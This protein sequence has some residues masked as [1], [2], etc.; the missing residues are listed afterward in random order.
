M[1]NLSNRI[2]LHVVI[3]LAFLA[4]PILM[5]PPGSRN[6][7]ET[8][9]DGHAWQDMSGYALTLIFFYLN[10]YYFIPGYYSRRRY[11][12]FFT[13]ILISFI[14]VSFLPNLLP[15][16]HSFPDMRRPPEGMN[17]P[18]RPQEM[19]PYGL[20]M[21]ELTMHLTHSLLRFL[22]VFF[23]SLMLKTQQQ[24]KEVKREKLDAELSYLKAQINPHF[25]FN[26]LNTIYSLSVEK[27]DNTPAAVTELAS[28]MRYVLDEARKDFVPLEKELAYISSYIKLQ[29]ARFGKTVDLKYTV[30]GQTLGKQ[31]APL[32]LIP[33]I[34]NAFKHGIN[35]EED[36]EI[37]IKIGITGS[38][39][40]LYVYNRKVFVQGTT[41]EK[42]GI[43]IEN[44][45]NR[46]NM[47]YPGRHLL[48][49]NDTEE[50]FSVNLVLE[51]A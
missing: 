33:Y 30:T 44:T 38:Q 21:G 49:I 12:S 20:R 2:V 11:V 48:T 24:L 18:M 5:P 3:C 31:I 15:L 35:P 40:M 39:L 47:I 1:K 36:A 16:Q 43:G 37:E 34:E 9:Q 10:Y 7:W 51:I 22:V 45:Y 19:H 29:E 25:L 50:D 42:S 14:A 6:I 13:L 32:V 27:S 28:M 26:T 8:L 23:I 46:L 17:M 4:L 41:A